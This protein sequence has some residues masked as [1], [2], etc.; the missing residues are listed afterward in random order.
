MGTQSVCLP[1][2]LRSKEAMGI[3]LRLLPSKQLAGIH[4]VMCE[5]LTVLR[6]AFVVFRVVF[7]DE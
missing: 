1:Q 6:S 4:E 3:H 2:E 5:A 7:L